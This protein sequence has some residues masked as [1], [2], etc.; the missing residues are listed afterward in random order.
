MAKL[1]DTTLVDYINF[2]PR[3]LTL[4]HDPNQPHIHWAREPYRLFPTV[5]ETRVLRNGAVYELEDGSGHMFLEPMVIMAESVDEKEA[6]A[7]MARIINTFSYLV[8]DPSIILGGNVFMHVLNGTGKTQPVIYLGIVFH[9]GLYEDHRLRF[10]TMRDIMR[11]LEKTAVILTYHDY[12]AKGL[13]MLNIKDPV[14]HTN[15]V[16]DIMSQTVVAPS[17]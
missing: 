7:C 16:R 15:Y 14:S 9:S 6:R 17:P 4:T 12:L 5:P 2:N 1:L 10:M 11:E 3:L 8:F 13:A